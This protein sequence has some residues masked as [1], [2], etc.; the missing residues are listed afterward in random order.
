MMLAL[1]MQD[2]ANADLGYREMVFPRCILRYF[3][4]TL[5]LPTPMIDWMSRCKDGATL[6]SKLAYA[7]TRRIDNEVRL[8]SLKNSSMEIICPILLKLA[9]QSH[10]MRDELIRVFQVVAMQGAP[11]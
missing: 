11:I 3:A 10:L 5:H 2:T 1:I 6:V 4:M 8:R 9:Q 7:L